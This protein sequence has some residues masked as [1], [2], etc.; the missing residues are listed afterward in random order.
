MTQKLTSRQK[1][2][3]H[4]LY[5][6]HVSTVDEM[7]RRLEVSRRTIQRDV[8][9][10]QSYL[11]EFQVELRAELGHIVVHGQ[12]G[13][14][15]RALGD[16][17]KLP[18][19]LALTPKDRAFY[20]VLE[21]LAHKGPLKLSYLGK[22][23]NVTSASVSHDLNQVGDWLR[24]RGLRLIRRPG[25]GVEVVGD[26]SLR[27]E[28]IAELVYEQLPMHDLMAVFRSEPEHANSHPLYA[29][30]ANWFG[31]DR[32]D[33]VRMILSE[34]LAALNPPLDEAA[35]YGFMLHVLLTC[36]RIEDDSYLDP[37]D[38]STKPSADTDLCRRI[39]R[40]LLPNASH[41]EGEAQ[42]LAKHLRGA[43]VMMTAES[44]ILPLNIT[45]MDVAF[46]LIQFLSGTLNL[47]LT[48][49]RDLL[50]GLAQHL[51]P[52]IY[53]IKA[54]L[55][56]RNP[57]LDEIRKR[58]PSLFEAMRE[59]S[60]QV[61]E[62]FGLAVLD[63]EIG[64][65]TMH[66]GAALERRKAGN[67]WRAKIVCP[68]GISSAELLASRMRNEFPQ[69]KIVS[70]E[71]I[72]ALDDTDCDFIVST[73]PLD[74]KLGKSITVSPFLDEHDVAGVQ[75]VLRELEADRL[76]V[77]E[78]H[79]ETTRGNVDGAEQFIQ[80]L[81]VRVQVHRIPA[82]RVPEM[83][84]RIAQDVV[85]ANDAT[86]VEHLFAAIEERER[87]GSIVLPGK[88]FSVLHARTPA[89]TRCHVSV[90][91]LDSPILMQGVGRQMER[92]NSVL[93][94]LAPVEESA[95]RIR[96]LGRLSSALVMDEHLVE[97]LR[98]ASLKEVRSAI[99]NAMN[100]TQE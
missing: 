30:F 80:D 46:Q 13:D 19:T 74:E 64:Y 65:L 100:H 54:G 23:L 14:F 27:L 22:K 9:A 96:L 38:T 62:P 51:E 39:L 24:S 18:K 47:R 32:L 20:V 94:L 56:I 87:L 36:M 57:L 71:S 98:A 11:K 43:K 75:S 97:A 3:L 93:V 88:Q 59:A 89:V 6:G 58:Y 2:I 5:D 72:H 40:R 29:W 86:D 17:G 26:E 25:Y 78:Q 90:Y 85:R 21:L 53:R 83:I 28:S 81:S 66:L 44:R 84:R 77:A 68:N 4:L 99:Y 55:V 70:V 95:G 41:V 10:L 35:F 31:R 7:V 61:L 79:I 52:A 8:T 73:V 91:R 63:A 69:V 37:D 92:V 67:K 49:D 82:E 12:Q 60:K 45:S 50:L 76:P 42:Y 15:L 16:S 48:E 34:E 33:D 1:Y